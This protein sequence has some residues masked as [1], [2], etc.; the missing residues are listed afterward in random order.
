MIYFARKLANNK[1]SSELWK[2]PVC[3]FFLQSCPDV[4]VQWERFCRCHAYLAALRDC[5]S[6]CR[7]GRKLPR[8]QDLLR[9]AVLLYRHQMA[10]LLLRLT[11]NFPIRPIRRRRP[12]LGGQLMQ[13]AVELRPPAR[14]IRRFPRA[15]TM[16]CRAEHRWA[17]SWNTIAPAV[18]PA[19]TN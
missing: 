17:A 16:D 13:A 2:P 4:R 11:I 3:E 12:F 19:R 9:P 7:P 8:L 15:A 10:R 1:T 5:C 14:Q 6:A 18:F